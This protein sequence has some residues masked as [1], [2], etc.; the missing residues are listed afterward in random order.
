MKALADR[1]GAKYLHFLNPHGLNMPGQHSTAMDA[2]YHAYHVPLIHHFPR[3][4]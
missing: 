1:L 4:K 2:A 3:M